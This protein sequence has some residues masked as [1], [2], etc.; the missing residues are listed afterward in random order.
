MSFK[1]ETADLDIELLTEN[2]FTDIV[3]RLDKNAHKGDNGLLTAVCGSSRYRGASAVSVGAAMRTGCG[4]VRLISVE[5]AVACTAARHPGA[6]F[7]PVSENKDGMLGADAYDVIR[8][9]AASSTAFL[10]GCGLGIS[11]DTASAVSAVASY[12]KKTVFDADALN[13]FAKSP[14]TLKAVRGEF[15]V[16]P[17]IGEMSRLTGKSISEIKSDPVTA[18]REFSLEYGCVTA[19]KDNEIYVSSEKGEICKS[20]L[21]CEG[22]A[23]GGSGD[24][25]VGF[26]A[27]FLARGYTPY[28]AAKAGC[29]LHGLSSK[30]AACEKGQTALLPEELELYAASVLKKLGY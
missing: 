13:I 7:C 9:S 23:K 4:I 6:T 2:S 17:H 12:S 21:G 16:T 8:A 30:A 18:A 19:L 10:C 25:L 22:L 15:I 14:E 11:S 29:V 20:S 26:I 1:K 5:K 27:G 24:A 3:K 28:E